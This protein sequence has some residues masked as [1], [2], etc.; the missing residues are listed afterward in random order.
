[1]ATVKSSPFSVI[2]L[3]VYSSKKGLSNNSAGQ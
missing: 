2:D 1:M 3:E